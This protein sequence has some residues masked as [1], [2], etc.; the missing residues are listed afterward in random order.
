MEPLNTCLRYSCLQKIYVGSND[1]PL[2]QGHLLPVSTVSCGLIFPKCKWSKNWTAWQVQPKPILS[3]RPPLSTSPWPWQIHRRVH[4]ATDVSDQRNYWTYP[5]K[6][7]NKHIKNWPHPDPGL[8]ALEVSTQFI[9]EITRQS[10]LPNYNFTGTVSL[11]EEPVLRLCLT[12]VLPTR[13]FTKL[14][15]Y[16]DENCWWSPKCCK[17]KEGGLCNQ[18]FPPNVTSPCTIWTRHNLCSTGAGQAIIVF[19]GWAGRSGPTEFMAISL[20]WT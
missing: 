6:P 4:Q 8:R 13:I 2:V 20:N 19:A 7:C 17:S 12:C 10:S 5:S 1:T 16:C 3:H 14:L 9:L 15:L 18:L 11:W